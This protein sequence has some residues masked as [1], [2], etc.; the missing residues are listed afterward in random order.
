MLAQ[1]GQPAAAVVQEDESVER[2]LQRLQRPAQHKETRRLVA[3]E[4]EHDHV[5]VEHVPDELAEVGEVV[6]VCGGGCV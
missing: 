1:R 4:E 6:G 2:A 5:G 3:V